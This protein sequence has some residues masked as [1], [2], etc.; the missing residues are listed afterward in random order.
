MDSPLTPRVSVTSTHYTKSSPSRPHAPLGGSA[1]VFALGVILYIMLSGT[2]PFG[3]TSANDKEIYA[4]V[5]NDALHFG[6]SWASVT[7]AAKELI[8]GLVEKDAAK[9]YTIEEALAHPWVSGDAASDKPI[10]RALATSLL[11][12]SAKNKFKNAAVRMVADHLTAKD[13][14]ALRAAFMKMDTDG[15]GTL[16]RSELASALRE[17][18]V[19]EKDPAVFRNM[20][21]AMD[22]DGDGKISWEEFL[23]ATLEA[24]MVKHQHQIWQT[25]CELDKDGSEKITIDELRT[26]LKVESDEVIK[27]Y[28][29]EYD[30]DKDG[31]INYEEFLRMLLP[32][33]LKFRVHKA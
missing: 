7:N 19:A 25:F 2:V 9:R 26:V 16:N 28:V 29:E 5:I 32:K 14:Q 18:G 20:V 31:M 17:L 8:A 6:D 24:Q 4:C 11:E 27:K 21:A 12:F 3:G 10:D 30:I 1:D 22:A 15:S 33:N 13:V 23:T